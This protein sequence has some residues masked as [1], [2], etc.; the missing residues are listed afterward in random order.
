[1]HFKLTCQRGAPSFIIY[2]PVTSTRI[3]ARTEQEL[4]NVPVPA[5]QKMKLQKIKK[6]VLMEGTAEKFIMPTL[7]LLL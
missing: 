1:M 3:P 6:A 2:L 7:K 4:D 5:M